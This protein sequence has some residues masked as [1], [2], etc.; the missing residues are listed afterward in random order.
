MKFAIAFPS[1][2][3]NSSPAVGPEIAFAEPRGQESRA[4]WKLPTSKNLS[5]CIRRRQCRYS[6]TGRN[7]AGSSRSNRMNRLTLAWH[8]PDPT[9]A[10]R[11]TTIGVT[12][13]STMGKQRK[14]RLKSLRFMGHLPASNFSCFNPSLARQMRREKPFETEVLGSCNWLFR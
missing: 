3:S 1:A 14:C 8:L 10:L 6:G 7:L 4:P 9:L 5:K 2:N 11:L 13:A 12:D